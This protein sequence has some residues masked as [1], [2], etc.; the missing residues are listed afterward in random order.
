MRCR[1]TQLEEGKEAK[2]VVNYSYTGETARTIFTR[3]K[4]HL[5][6][7]RSQLPGRKPT[8]SWMWQ[9]TLSHNAGIIGPDQGPE[10][11]QFRIQGRFNKTL[12]RQVDEAVH[13]GQ[14]DK[15]GQVLNDVGGQHG[16]TVVSQHS[17]GEYYQPRIVQY[18]F[19]N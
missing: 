13:L 5:S 12:E 11:N 10:D 9:H 14:I 18:N 19:E 15:D 6:D 2:D 3:S 7:Y 17:R 8:E 16:G 4:Q 1:S